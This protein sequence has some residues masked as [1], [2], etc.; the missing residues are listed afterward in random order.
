MN[1]EEYD[2]QRSRVARASLIEDQ[3]R[4]V[5]EDITSLKTKT[6]KPAEACVY[7]H[8]ALS[9]APTTAEVTDLIIGFLERQ[10]SALRTEF[11]Q[12]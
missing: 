2:K 5:L 9:S 6:G 7:L 12:L 1:K 3:L 4:R 8:N 11:A 10:A